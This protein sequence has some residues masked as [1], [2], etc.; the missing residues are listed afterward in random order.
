[1]DSETSTITSRDS[2]DSIKAQTFPPPLGY[3]L[4]DRKVAVAICWTLVLIDSCFIA[5]GLFYPLWYGTSMSKT[6]G[7]WLRLFFILGISTD[8]TLVMTIVSCLA[9]MFSL[10][11]FFWRAWI[12]WKRDQVRPID[13]SKWGF[14]MFQGIYTVGVVIVTLELVF[15]TLPDFPNSK[16]LPTNLSAMHTKLT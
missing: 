12:L 6:N 4:R 11:Q 10:F 8:Q 16:S 7:T 2:I 1:M 3:S 14:D 15:G 13:G 9:G 5:V